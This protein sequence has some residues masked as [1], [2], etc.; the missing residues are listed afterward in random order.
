MSIDNLN[1]IEKTY[2]SD[3]DEAYRSGFCHG[4]IAALEE[5][6][7]IEQAYNWRSD[8]KKIT[9]PGYPRSNIKFVGNS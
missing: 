6:V 9:P 2:I 5:N 3:E 7:T 8:K 1:E 4:V